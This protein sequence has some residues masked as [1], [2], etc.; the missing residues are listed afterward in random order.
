LIIISSSKGFIVWILITSAEIP[1]L[2]KPSAA[3]SDSQTRWPVA[4]IVTSL[5]SFS[6]IPFPILKEFFSEVKFGTFGLPN[7]K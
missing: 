6:K 3:L 4:I 1:F 5:P 7:L 2:N